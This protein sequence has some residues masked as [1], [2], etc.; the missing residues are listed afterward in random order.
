MQHCDPELLALRA[1]GEHAGTS[2]DDQHL[3]TCVLCQTELEQ[4]TSTVAVG[5]GLRS[6]PQLVD[7]PAQVWQRITAE[8]AAEASP[9]GGAEV[10]ALAPRRRWSTGLL[11]AASLV[12]LVAGVVGAVVL[13][14]GSNSPAPSSVVAQTDLAALK[15]RSG[16]GDAQVVTDAGNQM[17]HVDAT[18][19]TAG[20]GFYEVWLIDPKTFDMVGL[21]V[22]DGS[23]GDFAV[24]PGLNL[25]RYSVVDVSLEPYDGDPAHSRDSIVRGQLPV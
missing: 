7:P 3:L 15:D 16:V 17:L 25:A 14:D 23:T 21:G 8:L 19:L 20:K 12:S 11:V 9:A 18:G 10:I 5:R 24:P 22:L 6:D 1:L 2:D 13:T 4:L